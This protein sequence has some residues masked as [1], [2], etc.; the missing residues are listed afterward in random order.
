MPIRYLTR[1]TAPERSE[2]TNLHLGMALAVVAGALNAGGFL[3]VGQYT[4][5]MTGIVSSVADNLALAKGTAILAGLG[6]L[7]A[8]VL[9]AATTAILVNR[10]RR[11]A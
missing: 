1:L 10:A 7:V 5:H 2:R 11:H 3:A 9:G 6:S 8:F 4:S